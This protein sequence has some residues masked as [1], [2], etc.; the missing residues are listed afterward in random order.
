MGVRLSSRIKENILYLPF[1]HITMSY[2]RLN[3]SEFPEGWEWEIERKA[4][5]CKSSQSD[6]ATLSSLFDPIDNN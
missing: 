3:E 6:L 2:P 1:L 5:M 4:R